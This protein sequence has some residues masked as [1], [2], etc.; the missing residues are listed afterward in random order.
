MSI[1]YRK[2]SS[3]KPLLDKIEWWDLQGKLYAK[4]HAISA[5]MEDL[6]QY[7]DSGKHTLPAS[8]QYLKQYVQ[9][10][11]GLE[12]W[13]I[14]LKKESPS[15]IY[16]TSEHD[17]SPGARLTFANIQLGI[18][19]QD[20]WAL[21]LAITATIA[22]IA[23]QVPKEVPATFHAMLKQLDMEHGTARQIELA[24]NIMESM[25]YC[26]RDE[27]GAWSSQKCIFSG[28]VALYALRSHPPEHLR[29]Y[30]SV[31]RDLTEKKGF[32]YAKEL[33]KKEISRWTPVLAERK[34][35]ATPS[36]G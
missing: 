5:L 23:S 12:A 26:M 13:Y 28:R 4:G 31:F 36:H 1:Q 2:A 7:R 15:P 30:E 9:L 27:N 11:A 20:Y 16:W 33:D 3:V 34:R 17:S 14:E 8:A 10:N 21:R 25:S 35:T 6:D 32:R 18:V 24:T 29:K 19:M 22:G